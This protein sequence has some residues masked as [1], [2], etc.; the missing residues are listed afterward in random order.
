T[1]RAFAR[2]PRNSP[3]CGRDQTRTGPLSEATAVCLLPDRQPSAGPEVRRPHGCHAKGQ[4]RDMR[5]ILRVVFMVCMCCGGAALAWAQADG[6]ADL[7]HGTTLNGLA[8]V[9]IDSSQRGPALG[10]AAGWEVTPGLAI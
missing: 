9:A 2:L 10:G 4:G 6:S 1:P 3:R 8:G 7:R 5:T